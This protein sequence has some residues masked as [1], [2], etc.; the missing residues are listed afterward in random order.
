VIGAKPDGGAFKQTTY[1]PF[2]QVAAYAEGVALRT[3]LQSP[4]KM[5]D[6]YGE[7]PYIQTAAVYN[8]ES[9][10]VTVFATNLSPRDGVV[11]EEVLQFDHVELFEH[12]Q[13]HD[14]QPL[15]MNSLENPERVVPKKVEITDKV[16]LPPLSW[17]VLRYKVLS[18]R[19][20]V[21]E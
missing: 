17:N 9:G 6:G 2:S 10:I 13:I 18:E 16:V 1:Y 3:G 19:K 15:A 20:I 14:E 12:I 4:T 11:L 5:T 21:N 7:Q 8:E